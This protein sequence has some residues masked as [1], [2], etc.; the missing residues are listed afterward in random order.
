M[1]DLRTKGLPDTIDVGGSPFLIKTDFREWLKFSEIIKKKD[2]RLE[3]VEFL[4]VNEIPLINYMDGLVDFYV[5][6][7]AVPKE[8]PSLDSDEPVIDYIIDGE[9]IVS[10]FMNA[11]N[12][13]LTTCDMHWHMFKALLQ[14]LPETTRMKE[15]IS[16][17]SWR[18]TSKKEEQIRKELKESWSIP[19]QEEIL[20]EVTIEEINDLFY[21]S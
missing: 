15:I 5:N 12:I 17:R 11:Y 21:N 3:D 20:D 4:F 13:D 6:K 2:I 18:K 19:R 10:S 7:N 8:N 14:G 9:F 1:I 16:M